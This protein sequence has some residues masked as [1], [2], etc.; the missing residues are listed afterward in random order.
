MWPIKLNSIVCEYSPKCTGYKENSY[1]C[2]KALDKNYCGFY[3]RFVGE[4]VI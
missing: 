3:K 2:Q 4:C 1:T